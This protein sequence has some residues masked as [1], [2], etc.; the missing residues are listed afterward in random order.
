[1]AFRLLRVSTSSLLTWDIFNLFF[2]SILDCLDF[3][4]KPIYS[5]SRFFKSSSICDFFRIISSLCRFISSKLGMPFLLNLSSVYVGHVVLCLCWFTIFVTINQHTLY[6]LC[7]CWALAIVYSIA[8]CCLV[9][10]SLSPPDLCLIK[11]DSFRQAR[12]KKGS[13]L[14]VYS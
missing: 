4:A 13:S 8:I 9:L 5:Y 2:S 12:L 11:V 3:L 10:G 7:L 14:N 6:W 1:M